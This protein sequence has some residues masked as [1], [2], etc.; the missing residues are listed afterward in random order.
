MSEQSAEVRRFDDDSPES[1]I[2]RYGWDIDVLEEGGIADPGST[3]TRALMQMEELYNSV[4]HPQSLEFETIRDRLLPRPLEDSGLP[5][6]EWL[7]RLRMAPLLMMHMG[8]P[9]LDSIDSGVVKAAI[10]SA[11]SLKP[12]HGAECMSY[13]EEGNS[14]ECLHG[15]QCPAKIANFIYVQLSG[16]MV[17]RRV[18]Y[19]DEESFADAERSRIVVEAMRNSLIYFGLTTREIFDFQ[20]NSIFENDARLINAFEVV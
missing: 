3:Y 1:I 12:R 10:I 18:V 2:V 19:M 4:D 13:E 17:T 8:A 14:V 16:D 15:N 7:D 20:V 9:E 5:V 11:M 6:Y